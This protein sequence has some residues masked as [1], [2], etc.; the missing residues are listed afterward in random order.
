MPKYTAATF[1]PVQ[2]FI[3]KSRKL[4]DLDG[5]SLILSHLSE[6]LIK[7][8]TKQR[9][10]V[11]S[12]GLLDVTKGM[13]NR[14]LLKG[15]FS[16][17]QLREAL[18]NAWK[19]ILKECK[20]WIEKN[21]STT[22]PDTFYHWDRD[23]ELWGNHTWEIFWGSG[24]SISKAMDD[25]ETRKL[26]RNWTGINWIGESSSIT[27]TDAIAWNGMGKGTRNPK[28]LNYSQEKQE[29]ENFYNR[30]AA[31]LEKTG[32]NP[33][34]GKV[35]DLNERLC[36]PELVKRLVT[37]PNTKI[38]QKLGIT[39]I[40]KFSDL[41]RKPDPE[42]NIPGQW[43]GWFMGDG[44]KIGDHLKSLSKQPNGEEKIQ[45]FSNKMREWGE[46][47][48][49]DFPKD[50]GR[51]IYAGGDDFLGVIYPKNQQQTQNHS[52]EL[53]A[54]A[55]LWLMRLKS[56]WEKHQQKRE[57]GTIIT[58]SLGFVW[59]GH[60]VPQRDILQHCRE[61]EKE[62]KNAGR[63]RVAIRIVFNSGQYVQWICPWD[64]LTILKEYQDREG[65]KNW[66]H[67]YKD[68]AQLKSRH[69]INKDSYRLA[70]GLM[71]IYFNQKGD[72]FLAKIS[73]IVGETSY[74]ALIDWIDD[75]IQ[76]SW[77]IYA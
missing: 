30:L 39:L 56:Q 22:N 19:A 28:T 35:L 46:N 50:L 41:I 33:P 44:D 31:A 76:V 16:E 29:I 9:C 62:A 66:S 8:A 34:E 51:V 45:V 23:W 48:E 61:A 43:T 58:F 60:S 10:E 26:S 77:Q 27:G 12:P 15:E 38:P 72:Y 2:G 52:Q 13:P 4:R 21:V 54:K 14:I 57:D 55:V 32:E 1:S 65:G 6:S 71:N 63:D 7:V 40:D 5:A 37:L 59:A 11:I 17:E 36:I 69:A 49:K 73:K 64:E 42:N 75:L 70:V 53:K 74:P 47:F 67:I 18:L 20:E 24:E 68:W 3:E 25:L